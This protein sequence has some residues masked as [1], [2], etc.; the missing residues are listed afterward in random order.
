MKRSKR[1]TKKSTKST[2]SKSNVDSRSK[3]KIITKKA[4][5]TS[6]F[7]FFIRSKDFN[8]VLARNLCA[9]FVQPETQSPLE[10]GSGEISIYFG[11]NFSFDKTSERFR[12][13][14]KELK[15]LVR[16]EKVTVVFDENPHI[17]R[18]TDAPISAQIKNLD[19]HFDEICLYPSQKLLEK[20]N[21]P[22][23]EK[24]PFQRQLLLGR[25]QIS[26]N[27]FELKV[28]EDYSNDPRF[29]FIFTDYSGRICIKEEYSQCKITLDRDKTFIDAFSIGY[30]KS[31][32][33]RVAV[34]WTRDLANFT[35]EHQKRWETYLVHDECL[36]EPDFYKNQV[37]A[38]WAE[39]QGIYS[40]F[41]EE[42]STI[43]KICAEIGWPKL[44][45]QE[46]DECPPGFRIPFVATSKNFHNFA[47][48]LDKL[49]SE[50]I[51]PAF[52]SNSLSDPEKHILQKDGKS[53]Q[54]KKI[55]LG[56]VGLLDVWIKKTF[57]PDEGYKEIDEMISCFKDIRSLRSK[58]SHKL[59]QNIYGIEFDK[60]HDALM[61][62]AYSSIRLLRL[63]LSNHPTVRPRIQSIVPHH[64]FEGKIR[65][66]YFYSLK[67]LASPTKN[68]V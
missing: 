47:Q 67:N 9:E 65:N 66:Y 44:F 53:G 55:P 25:P 50:N 61:N 54:E 11:L 30:K 6:I 13:F 68:K 10:I 26:P 14:I 17:K 15:T 4:L 22:G 59:L 5:I 46:F 40:A 2:R 64:L 7:D 23:F 8:G 49:V 31:N 58:E 1:I 16:E 29:N 21:P 39:N 60:H 35:S 12:K 45:K 38:Q 28:L 24:S 19:S 57:R 48:L 56:T 37:L 36:V 18:Y 43:N 20:I 62:Q 41:L 63:I 33:Q 32:F 52:F 34:V 51:D 27:F 3:L 42:I